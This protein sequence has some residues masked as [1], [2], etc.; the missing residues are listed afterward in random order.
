M[1]EI[2]ENALQL[3]VAGG[4]G[5]VALSRALRTRD[6]IWEFLAL[7]Y[8]SYLLGDLYWLLYRVFY[9]QTPQLFYVSDLC[10]YASYIFLYQLLLQASEGDERRCRPWAAWLGPAFAAGMCLFY[11]R[12]GDY[13]GNAISGFLM[14]RLLFHIIRGLLFMKG[15]RGAARRPLYIAVLVF[16][17]AEYGDWTTSC[18][19]MGDT[20]ANPY[21]WFD[22]LITIS[23]AALLP[24]T[25]KAARA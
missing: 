22:L 2:V 13:A 1:I 10:W 24:A 20:L 17:A 18:Y 12:W 11:M 14:G 9:G 25:G 19:W 16:C 3:L 5:A 8:G 7:V 6:N 15:M 21:F 23:L 4:C